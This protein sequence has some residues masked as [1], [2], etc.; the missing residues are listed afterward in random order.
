M[1][2]LVAQ[3]TRGV[4]YLDIIAIKDVCNH[5]SLDPYIYINI[6]V[7]RQVLLNQNNSAA[8]PDDIPE[9]FYRKLAYALAIL[10]C[11]VFQQSIFHHSILDYVPSLLLCIREREIDQWQVHLGP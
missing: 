9:I 7:V 8:G 5:S 11:I 2:Q 4:N 6:D 3:L 1:H 10:Q